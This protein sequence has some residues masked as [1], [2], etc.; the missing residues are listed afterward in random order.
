[1]RILL[2]LGI[3]LPFAQETVSISVHAIRPLNLNDKDESSAVPLKIFL[4]KDG[5]RFEKASVNDLWNKHRE[6]LGADRIRAPKEIN[7]LGGDIDDT[8]VPIDLGE[9][10]EEMRFVGVVALMNKE[11]KGPRKLLIA[12]KDLATVIRIT[13]Y[14]LE[15]EK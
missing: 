15:P 5:D 9:A 1:M 14:H 10:P 2:A 6:V 12:K 13:G 8:A 3:L 11:D 7:V 4:L